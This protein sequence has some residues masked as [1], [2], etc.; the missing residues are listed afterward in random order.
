VPNHLVLTW[1]KCLSNEVEAA[2]FSNP[3]WPEHMVSDEV[4]TR[5]RGDSPLC[6]NRMTY[7][8]A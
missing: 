2:V 3:T 6:L 1:Q 4:S 7:R 5:V 8:I